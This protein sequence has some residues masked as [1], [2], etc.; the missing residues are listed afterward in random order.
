MINLNGNTISITFFETW[1]LRFMGEKILKFDLLKKGS[2][3][4]LIN[5]P[6]CPGAVESTGIVGVQ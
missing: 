3:I 1:I 2:L 6:G 4:F 5:V